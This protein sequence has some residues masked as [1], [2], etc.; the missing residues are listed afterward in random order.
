MQ[1]Y[2]ACLTNFELSPINAADPR[3]VDSLYRCDWVRLGVGLTRSAASGHQFATALT[4]LTLL[5]L[6]W[7]GGRL[8]QNKRSYTAVIAF[9]APSVCLTLLWTYHQNYDM[10]LLAAPF[11]LYLYAPAS[12]RKQMDIGLFLS[13]VFIFV[14]FYP[15][16][17]AHHLL[18]QVFGMKGVVTARFL[19]P[20][21]MTSPAG[22]VPFCLEPGDK[23]E[24]NH[25]SPE[26]SADDRRKCCRGSCCRGN[27]T[28]LRKKFVRKFS[29]SHQPPPASLGERR[30]EFSSE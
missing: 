9:L 17:Q 7:Q 22:H 28:I 12:E 30:V 14:G 24:R 25:L 10:L 19:V 6:G 18:L 26:R 3:V 1:D 11:I 2:R 13:L 21:L 27:A 8:G 5:Y 15:L 16:A 4:L 29:S 20:I 23:A